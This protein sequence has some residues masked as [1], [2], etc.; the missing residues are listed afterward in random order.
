MTEPSRN[1]RLNLNDNEIKEAFKNSLKRK[2]IKTKFF[3][4][5][6]IP[7][8][9]KYVLLYSFAGRS[10]VMKKGK[11]TLQE[12]TEE[13]NNILGQ[14]VYINSR[15]DVRRK[16]YEIGFK[17]QLDEMIDELFKNY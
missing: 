14:V 12:R 17:G 10:S 2:N 16:S 8:S 13:G 11:L 5:N 1:I 3:S 9:C 4:N 7:E 6:E 15:G